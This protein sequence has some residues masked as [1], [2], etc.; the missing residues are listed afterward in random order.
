MLEEG[1]TCPTPTA[2]EKNR[3]VDIIRRMNIDERLE[4]LAER[5]EAEAERWSVSGICHRKTKKSNDRTKFCWRRTRFGLPRSIKGRQPGA[6]R[7]CS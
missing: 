2:S 3:A 6:H 5:H 1:R 7:S 4:R